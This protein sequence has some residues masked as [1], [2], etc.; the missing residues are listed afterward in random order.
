MTTPTGAAA[1]GRA[2][3]GFDVLVTSI[4]ALNASVRN[5]NN[6]I[7]RASH[8]ASRFNPGAGGYSPTAGQPQGG[9]G[10]GGG[11]G[12]PRGPAPAPTL[13]QTMN[14]ALR[15]PQGRPGGR[16]TNGDQDDDT[17]IDHGG[18]W[19]NA[20]LNI[21]SRVPFLGTA[22]RATSAVSDLY[23]SERE[24]NRF[25]QGMEGGENTSGF[26]ERMSEEGYRW[27]MGMG[28]SGSMARQSFKGVTSLGYT[29]KDTSGRQGRQDALNFVYHNLN[30]RGMDVDESLGMLQ[31]AS[32]DATVSFGDLS[33]ALKDVSDTAGEAGVNA[34]L[35]RQSFQQMLDASIDTGAGAGAA[36]LAGI[37]SATQASYGRSFQG[38][39]MTGQLS[40]N[41]QYMI[42]AKAGVTP[43]QL[44]RTM[45]DNPKQ[46]AK[47]S[48][49]NQMDAIKGSPVGAQ[50]IKLIQDLIKK[51]GSTQ[52]SVPTIEREFLDASGIDVNVLAQVL[53][54]P[55]TGVELDA[56]NV[57]DWVIQQV[58]GNSAAAHVGQDQS[59]KPVPSSK[60]DPAPKGQFG[61]YEPN[62]KDTPYEGMKG[63][64]W[65][66]KS[67]GAE[68]GLF[69]RG[70]TKAGET[71][72]EGMKKSGNRDPVLEA[73][74]QNIKDP[75][76]TN[77]VVGTATGERVVSLEEAMRLFPDSLARGDARIVA[78]S[79][80]GQKISDVV[81][82]NVDVD[83]DISKELQST[84][85]QKAGQSVKDYSS[86]Y[87]M[88]PGDKQVAK[89]LVTVDLTEEAKQ[90][91]KLLPS[92]NNQSSTT[93]YPPANPNSGQ[94]SR[95]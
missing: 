74:L 30:T 47:L 90:L 86:K 16:R 52:Q 64:E 70:T 28:M 23:Q 42:G 34:K 57:V 92:I 38:S 39:D 50:G 66:L 59:M 95:N 61:L 18:G 48:A 19:T 65:G 33:K 55:L 78:G 37:F 32:R 79:H 81:E 35:M 7:Q 82:G 87:G 94:A 89:E 43:S 17:E 36:K 3:T 72:V 14:R 45:R 75:D 41:Y 49:A 83:R 24:K 62:D 80:A 85:G 63:V 46:Y 53:S 56:S 25:Y 4:D 6:D 31:T 2:A 5:L 11:P 10:A 29:G 51:Y 20:A 68:E 73:I 40:T 76:K 60:S 12:A 9:G 58:M 1:S 69:G 93:G 71:Y 54:G 8:A 77:V 26:G 15:G 13:G 67:K 27:S 84:E 91:L 88:G 44:Q 22:M 21:G